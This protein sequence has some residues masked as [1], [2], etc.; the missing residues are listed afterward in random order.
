MFLAV[1]AMILLS[2][3]IV[4]VN[5]NSLLTEDV[6]Y[7][8]NFGITATSIATSI[9]EDAS[10]KR[11]DNTFYIDSSAVDDPSNFTPIENLGIDSGEV[12]TD[13][14]T[15]NDFDDYHGYSNSD[16]TMANQTAI[17]DISCNVNY[18]NEDN[19]DGIASSQT[20]HKKITVRVVS[21]SMK[22]TIVLSSI[23]SYWNFLP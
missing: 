19:P 16:T 5:K 18:I 14:K 4:N 15:F 3:V 17:F 21:Q 1:G 10:K 20:F 23:F 6:M 2:M 12:I 11:F 13:P 7:D 8:S 22:D 9:I